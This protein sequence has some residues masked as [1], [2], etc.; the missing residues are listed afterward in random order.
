MTDF[1]IGDRVKM[2]TDGIFVKGVVTNIRRKGEIEI[3]WD[4]GMK[5][6]E[7]QHDLKR[8][9]PKKKVDINQLAYFWNVYIWNRENKCAEMS[10]EFK[11]LCKLVGVK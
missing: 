11:K 5:S 8:L 7:Y 6:T 10:G 1:K 3:K 2:F 4:D 9:K